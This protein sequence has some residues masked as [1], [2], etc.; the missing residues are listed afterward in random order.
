MN[1]LTMRINFHSTFQ[2]ELE[3]EKMREKMRK[4]KIYEKVYFLCDNAVRE[5][6]AKEGGKS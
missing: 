6:E 5:R 4:G 2:C 1:Y 3:E